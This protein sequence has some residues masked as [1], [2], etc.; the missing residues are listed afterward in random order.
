MG[1]RVER[2]IYHYWV[3]SSRNVLTICWCIQSG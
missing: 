3:Y 2:W 1:I